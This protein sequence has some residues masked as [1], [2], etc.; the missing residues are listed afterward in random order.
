M[1]SSR[2][3]PETALFDKRRE[4]K[5]EKYKILKSRN[6]LVDQQLHD[7]EIAT[8]RKGLKCTISYKHKKQN[9][10]AAL[11]SSQKYLKSK[12]RKLP[13]RARVIQK[14]CDLALDQM[15]QQ[16]K[17]MNLS[18]V[19]HAQSMNN[20]PL[21]LKNTEKTRLSMNSSLIN[22]TPRFSK[23]EIEAKDASYRRESE[24]ARAR[25]RNSTENFD[26]DRLISSRSQDTMNQ[27]LREPSQI[28]ATE[29]SDLAQIQ[30]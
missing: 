16:R 2:L 14:S 6:L 7:S 13:R 27:S 29:V 23:L 30:T 19:E 4:A 28:G 12:S 21:E 9:G 15:L 20:Q 1:N 8:N 5:F 26:N 17:E 24:Q 3:I 18:L 11:D 10:N 25:Q 22:L